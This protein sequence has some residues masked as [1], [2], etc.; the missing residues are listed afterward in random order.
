MAADFT[1]VCTVV[2]CTR[3][4]PE[5][6]K[7]CLAAVTRMEYSRFDVLVVDNAPM[8]GGAREIAAHCGARYVVEPVVGLS[9]ARNLGSHACQ[10]EIL[11]YL[12]DDAVPE[13]GWLTA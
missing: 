6:L 2:V 4:R 11:A 13:R 3:D 8:N 5:E 12:D 9:R 7:R 10:S 1:P